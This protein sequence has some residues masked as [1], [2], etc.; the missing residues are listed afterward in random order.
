MPFAPNRQQTVRKATLDYPEAWAKA[1]TAGDDG[2]FIRIAARLLF[3]ENPRF[4]LNG[5]RGT[6]DISQDAICYTTP[7]G[8]GAGGVEIYDIIAGHG[9]PGARAA[10][11][12]VTQATIDAGTVGRWFQPPPLP[13][14]TPEPP[15]PPPPPPGGDEILDKPLQYLWFRD[16]FLRIQDAIDRWYR[17][18]RG[19][20]GAPTT[21]LAHIIWRATR[22]HERWG[23]T[24][25]E[26]LQA[27]WPISTEPPAPP[28]IPPQP[29]ALPSLLEIP[30]QDR[31]GN[32]LYPEANYFP[33][34]AAIKG[35]EAFKR[36]C[37]WNKDHG[38]KLVLINWEQTHWGASRGKPE[39]T[40]PQQYNFRTDTGV[41]TFI[42]F[43]RMAHEEYG[44]WPVVGLFEQDTVRSRDWSKIDNMARKYI[45]LLNDHCVAFW[46]TWE[47][48]EALSR[49]DEHK[50]FASIVDK[51]ATKP[52][53]LHYT[54]IG[55]ERPWYGPTAPSYWKDMPCDL[56]W[57]Q[58]GF[59]TPSPPENK[60]EYRTNQLV[61]YV[62]DSRRQIKVVMAEAS[63]W[64]PNF[65]M[66]GPGHSLA[67]AGERGKAGMR[68]GAIARM[69]G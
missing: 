4:G 12:D 21:A 6:T 58:Y 41:Q 48:D 59:G 65:W 43:L 8:S 11:Q 61:G 20:I 15:P 46:D 66:P 9:A 22:E 57:A 44:L 25:R 5:K 34:A 37:Q 17:D 16:N 40:G 52:H 28:V 7:D 35:Q 19:M 1:Q 68:G 13:G 23:K 51:Y 14:P 27:S 29:G 42:R 18:H 45:P 63:I 3:E 38:Y 10:W 47:I 67:E 56:I 54:D 30:V 69:N 24:L 64:G 26:V 53:G 31:V 62:K 2:S 32:F 33:P 39:W 55:E 36:M 60:I 49:E 50:R